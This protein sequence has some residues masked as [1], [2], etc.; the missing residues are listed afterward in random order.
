MS[1]VAVAILGGAALF[2]IGSGI[3]KNAQAKKQA[4][5][6]EAS[7][8]KYTRSP[9]VGQ[10]LSLAE[11]ELMNN[12]EDDIMRQQGDED[13][14]A[15]LDAIMKGGGNPNNVSAIFGE[16]Q[17][18]R[19]RYALIRSNIR[20]NKIQNLQRAQELAE[21]DRERAFG[22]NE[23]APYKDRAAAIAQ[24]AQSAQADIS[25][26]VDSLASAVGGGVSTAMGARKLDNSLKTTGG[27]DTLDTTPLRKADV[28]YNLDTNYT[29]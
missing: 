27:A 9:Y 7:R 13:L 4:A 10:Q 23:V 5:I 1:G 21:E 22:F 14:S 19:Q 18:G 2:K 28:N 8:P 24:S 17:R 15:S 11:S 3:V 16:S 12:Q 25:S 6:N 29:G 20:M 26:G